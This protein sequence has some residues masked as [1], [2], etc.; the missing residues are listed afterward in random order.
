MFLYPLSHDHNYHFWEIIFFSKKIIIKV[1]VTISDKPQTDSKP[2]YCRGRS[3]TAYDSAQ[4]S[5]E[6][7]LELRLR[8]FL[9]DIEDR[10]YQGTLGAIK[11][12]ICS[13]F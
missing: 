4:M 11:V 1:L 6:R 10:I 13:H 3:S 2:T 5:A 9:L 12:C 7:Q 8:D